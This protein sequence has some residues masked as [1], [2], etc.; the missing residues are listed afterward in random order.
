[1]APEYCP[2]T[3]LKG[4]EVR[5]LGLYRAYKGYMRFFLGGAVGVGIFIYNI[6]LYGP[7]AIVL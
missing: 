1:M 2:L 5:A 6:F 3:S 7:V 4:S